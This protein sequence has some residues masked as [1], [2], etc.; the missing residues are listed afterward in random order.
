M[1]TGVHGRDPRYDAEEDA[2]ADAEEV[3]DAVAPVAP[4]HPPADLT[5]PS[6]A[7]Q[8]ALRELA[9]ALRTSVET[10][11]GVRDLQ[12]ELVKSLKR[13]D[14]SELVLQST[15]ALNDTFRNLSTIQR[16]LVSRLEGAPQTGG[17][18]RIIP[19]LLLGLLVVFLGGVYVVLDVLDQMRAERPD[20]ALVA[21]Q[22]SQR[23]LT[24][25]RE[26]KAE[27]G[28]VAELALSRLQD[29]LQQMEERERA[30]RLKL[31]AETG[32]RGE[33]EAEI[34]GLEVERDGLAAQ[35]RAAQS[36][37]LARR[38]VEEELRAVNGQLAVMEPRMLDLEASLRAEK[39]E[40]ARLRERLGAIGLGRP[41]P[42][43]ADEAEGPAEP[44]AAGS[45][46]EE[47]PPPL[48]PS[49]RVERDPVLLDK[50]R[51][52]LNQML[53]QTSQGRTDLWQVTRIDGVHPEGLQ[54]VIA[55]R[56][57]RASGRLLQQV[58]ARDLDLWVD[59][60]AR[61]V[62]FEFRNGQSATSAG[63]S[64][65]AGG[66]FRQ[67]VADGDMT[68]VWSQSGMTFLRFR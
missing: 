10:M 20:T 9:L 68:R 33:R 51:D 25:F 60:E 38:A 67:T 39:S 42:G 64:Q 61:A 50:I 46:V 21:E 36:E 5:A 40:N 17:G 23:T 31:D 16:E 13:Q 65:F 24:A 58:Q 45:D 34:R 37:V 52:R 41:D 63:S 66:T 28:D 47:R 27:G 18:G 49:R 26:G 35:I 55:L 30:L 43:A 53:D 57:D 48:V 4:R 54:G 2:E 3:G 8:E 19:L 6:T 1:E 11:H 12:A 14:R 29:Q 59:R 15:Q 62:T 22:A 44:D 7:S 56:Y 32:G